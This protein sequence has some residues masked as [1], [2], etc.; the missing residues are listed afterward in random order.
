MRLIPRTCPSIRAS[1][2]ANVFLS[3]SGL[4]VFLHEQ[5]SQLASDTS[6]FFSSIFIPSSQWLSSS[7]VQ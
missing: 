2:D 1:L 5:A 7:V 6:L 3:S 4:F